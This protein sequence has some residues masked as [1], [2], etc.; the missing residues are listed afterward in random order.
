MS[1]AGNLSSVLSGWP[2]P[3]RTALVDLSAGRV[4]EFS[5]GALSSLSDSVARG[6]H[7]RFGSGRFRVG[8]VARNSAE[9]VALYFGTM[10]A[11]GVAVPISWKLPPEIL[12]Y[13]LT[14]ASVDA[15]FSDGSCEL[16]NSASAVRIDRDWTS[17]LD[18]GCFEPAPVSRDSLAQIL[19]TS[20]STGRPKGVPLTHGGQ[21]W[22]VEKAASLITDPSSY[23][24]LVAAP[25][26]HMNALF[27]VKRTL[28]CRSTVVLLPHFTA[29]DYERA[30]EEFHCDWVTCVPAMMALLARHLGDRVLPPRFAA[31]RRVF[32]SS[33]SFSPQLL[34]T[35]QRMFPNAHIANSYGTTEAGP[36][37]FQGH[38][39][40]LPTPP[41]SCG[42]PYSPDHVR[43]VGEDERVIQGE[44]QGVLEMNT[45]ATASGYLN[46]P[47]TSAQLFRDGWYNSRDIMRRDANGFYY[48]MGR[49]DDMFTCGG[50][51]IYP[52]EVEQIL[53]RHPDIEQ[54]VVVPVPDEIKQSL[55]VAFVVPRSGANL[56]EAPLKKWF[57]DRAPGFMCPRRI[58]F[59][60]EIPL[61]QTNKVDRGHL[62]EMARE[63]MARSPQPQS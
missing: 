19:Y 49:V 13:V 58:G 63:L 51:N 8:I 30:I 56:D 53:E 62:S 55:P 28:Y 7:S 5:F 22:A 36:H 57:L 52:I 29:Q 47:E 4:R 20:G 18:P 16:P 44:G 59:V 45:P 14:D 21:F 34:A 50:E 17:F 61:A 23:R 41:M 9:F 40:G 39:N 54:A 2:E 3:E 37:V 27:N 1:N 48:F 6:L 38:P 12:E 46:L 10:R 11:G 60:K 32:M 42:H 35:V 43:L 33:S 25:L 24:V 26:F 31:V 15:V